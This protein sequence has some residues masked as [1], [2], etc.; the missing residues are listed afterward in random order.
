MTSV[1]QANVGKKWEIMS[2]VLGLTRIQTA[3]AENM[4]RLHLPAFMALALQPAGAVI[5]FFPHRL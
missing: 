2:K 1:A 5:S 3:F 4:L